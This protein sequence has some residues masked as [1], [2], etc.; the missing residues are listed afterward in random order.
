MAWLCA[1]SMFLKVFKGFCDLW[2]MIFS[3]VLVFC[4]S[5]NFP[6]WIRTCSLNLDGLKVYSELL[7]KSVSE[8]WVVVG[9]KLRYSALQA[10]R[11]CYSCF[12]ISKSYV[13]RFGLMKMFCIH[14]SEVSD[15]FHLHFDVRLHP[16]KV[17]V[18]Y[19]IPIRICKWITTSKVTKFGVQ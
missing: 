14:F 16:K 3:S 12:L 4:S 10:H 2:C 5:L 19:L 13:W 6:I 1:E 8:S 15:F 7:R 17:L 11:S 18:S 9:A